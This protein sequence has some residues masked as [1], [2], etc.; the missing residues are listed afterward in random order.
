MMMV[1]PTG[2]GENDKRSRAQNGPRANPPSLAMGYYPRLVLPT[3]SDRSFF[4]A[5]L[6]RLASLN[7][8]RS[9][10]S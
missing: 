1:L 9:V 3:A 8:V 10:Q 4:C 2:V 7:S 6:G 5:L